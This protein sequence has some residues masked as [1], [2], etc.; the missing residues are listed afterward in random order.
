[1]VLAWS[2]RCHAC[3]LRGFEYSR[4]AGTG[5]TSLP[6]LLSR[7]N[8]KCREYGIL[9]TVHVYSTPNNTIL[10]IKFNTDTTPYLLRYSHGCIPIAKEFRALSRPRILSH[11][12][13]PAQNRTSTSQCIRLFKKIKYLSVKSFMTS[14]MHEH[15][16]IKPVNPMT[17]RVGFGRIS[18][19]THMVDFK[20]IF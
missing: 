19:T 14:L 9:H 20:V 12:N 7:S 4:I 17:T 1:M 8:L 6:L 16:V 18:N 10:C 11:P 3:H 15:K 2:A 5:D 13:S